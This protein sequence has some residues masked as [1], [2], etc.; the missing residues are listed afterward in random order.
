MGA[1]V[2]F[3]YNYNSGLMSSFIAP[4]AH[5]GWNGAASA[6]LSGGLV[7]GL[8]NDN[9]NYAGGFTSVDFSAGFGGYVSR[10]SGG[11]TG[12]PVN[13]P[14]ITEV[15]A[16]AGV[17]AIPFPTGGVELSN[18]IPISS[19]PGLPPTGFDQAMFFAKQVC[20]AISQ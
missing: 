12:A 7:W 3:V 11:L 10:S 8:T 2:Q 15:G 13:G 5:F 14:K 4:T 18:S 16:S 17:T 6:S 20:N 19:A 1:A 9:S